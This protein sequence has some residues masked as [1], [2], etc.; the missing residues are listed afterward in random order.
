MRLIPRH[1]RAHTN[2]DKHT[3]TLS[4]THTPCQAQY[5]WFTRRREREDLLSPPLSLSR[6]RTSTHTLPTP[7]HALQALIS[8]ALESRP[9]AC[10][11]GKK[12]E[13]ADVGVADSRS[14]TWDS[15]LE[16]ESWR[17]GSC[18]PVAATPAAVALFDANLDISIGE[19]LS[20]AS[21]STLAGLRKV[22]F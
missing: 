3:H 12:D 8:P 17:E 18:A 9:K 22:Q 10:C 6:A 1:T 13:E 16:R 11:I 7:L 20:A 2:Y 5:T 21:T 19:T 14:G 4:L 15:W